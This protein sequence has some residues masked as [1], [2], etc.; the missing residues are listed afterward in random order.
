[1]TR[2]L[3]LW[4]CLAVALVLVGCEVLSLAT[5]RRVGGVGRALGALSATPL[6]MAVAF[7]CWMWIGWHFF[8]R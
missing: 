1:M 7:L 2:Q 4:G 8:A 6:G 5:H 3:V